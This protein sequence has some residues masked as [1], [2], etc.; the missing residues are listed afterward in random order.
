MWNEL[1]APRRPYWS[2]YVYDPR[3]GALH[4]RHWQRAVGYG[5][6][7]F[8]S[9][10]LR[11]EFIKSFEYMVHM[12]SGLGE[13]IQQEIVAR[14]FRE[15]PNRRYVNVDYR[16]FRETPYTSPY[17]PTPKINAGPKIR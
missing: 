13:G 10:S 7:R 14:Y 5:E 4:L 12:C 16:N 8:M 3:V 11:E 9:G 2:D 6:A 1:I 15:H 17:G